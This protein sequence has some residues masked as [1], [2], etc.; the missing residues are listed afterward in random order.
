[1]Y[2][3]GEEGSQSEV[4]FALTLIFIYKQYNSQ[5]KLMLLLYPCCSQAATGFDQNKVTITSSFTYFFQC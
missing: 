2:S 5:Q 3:Q 4:N 1:M